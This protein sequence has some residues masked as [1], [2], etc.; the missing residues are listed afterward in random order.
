[1]DNMNVYIATHKKFNVPEMEIYNPI[2]VGS[3]NKEKFGYLRD[4]TGNNISNK[5]A[6]YCELT[7]L[8]WI[9]KNDNSN[10]VGLTHYRRY[11][12]K[13]KFNN[14]YDK[15]LNKNDILKIFEKYDLI[16]PY[17]NYIFKSNIKDHY[18]K[19]HHIEDFNNCRA[20][21]EKIY[22]EYLDSFDLFSTK[23]SF[24]AYNMF[25]GKKE[26]INQYCEWL[27][28]ILFELEKITDISKYDNYNK[29]IYGFLSERLF[30][31]WLL[32]NDNLLIK[33]MPVN[34]TDEKV[35]F[36]TIKNQIKK[37]IIRN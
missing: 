23:K 3:I 11:F 30:N 1:M 34:N 7:A 33:K 15:L 32:K 25:I 19:I 5:N 2:Q 14:S 8:Y 12:F 18:A 36:Q 21:I 17:P 28:N 9:W 16:V 6:N 22:P 31:V 35:V 13:T 20:I 37:I 27:F 26:I 29:R 4:D 10:I 24:F